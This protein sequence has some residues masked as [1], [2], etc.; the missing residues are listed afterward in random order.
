MSNSE[1]FETNAIRTQAEQS[2][3]REHSVPI[4]MTSS[5]TFEDAEQGR[6]LFA[7]EIEGNI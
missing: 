2:G 7:D 5:F 4:Y 1:H 3:F 6:A